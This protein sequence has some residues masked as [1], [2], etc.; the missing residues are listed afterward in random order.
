MIWVSSLTET[1]PSD[2]GGV[3]AGHRPAP[4]VDSPIQ[5]AVGSMPTIVTEPAPY[6]AW[7]AITRSPDVARARPR[8]SSPAIAG[9]SVADAGS[10]PSS[11]RSAA[12]GT[13]TVDVGR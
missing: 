7:A 4:A 11:P 2:R 8:A 1:V 6:A 3:R 12:G 13:S 9:T 5:P 10:V